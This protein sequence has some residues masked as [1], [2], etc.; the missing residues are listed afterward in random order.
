VGSYTDRL[1]NKLNEPG[2]SIA[3]T[4][5]VLAY[6]RETIRRLTEKF[7]EG[8]REVEKAILAH[9]ASLSRRVPRP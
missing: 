8:A 1:Y 3:I 7:E 2:H 9:N 4:Q 5:K 6:H